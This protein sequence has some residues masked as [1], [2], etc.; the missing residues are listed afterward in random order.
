MLEIDIHL[1]VSTYLYLPSRIEQNFIKLVSAGIKQMFM[2]K[3][4]HQIHSAIAF[5]DGRM[6]SQP[7]I[8]K[9]CTKQ[10]LKYIAQS[11]IILDIVLFVWEKII[12]KEVMIVINCEGKV[13]FICMEILL[14]LNARGISFQRFRFTCIII[15]CIFIAI[16][17]RNK[18]SLDVVE[19]RY[20]ERIPWSLLYDGDNI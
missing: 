14:T 15:G 9:Q 18:V 6:E 1:L 13:I 10:G 19:A 4:T 11:F 5:S 17:Q 3:P 8:N 20:W 7:S 2:N 12:R 16:A